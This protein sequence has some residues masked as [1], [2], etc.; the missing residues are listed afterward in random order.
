MQQAQQGNL[1]QVHYSGRLA[2]GTEF[3]SS[4]GGQPLSFTIGGGE[5]IPGFEQAVLGMAAGETRSVSIPADQAYGPVIDEM[6]AVVPRAELPPGL[7]LTLGGQ[8]EVTREDGDS[9]LV[10]VT[11]LTDESVTLDA[12]HPLAGKELIFDLT[13]LAII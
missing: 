5:V 9:F 10:M 1:V 4:V 13:L 7:E 6:V 8:L 2:D 12:N 11:G 3:D